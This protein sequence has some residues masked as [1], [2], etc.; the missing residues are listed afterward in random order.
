MPVI[1]LPDGSRREYPQPLTV[2]E[3]AADIGA[4]LAKAAL[5]G[6][7]NGKLVDTSYRVETDAALS[8][9]TDT[10][11]EGAGDRSATRPRTCWRRLSRSCFPRHR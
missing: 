3:V 5:A 7:V 11:P 4:G 2:A 1:T 6:K 10:S 8:I 9:I